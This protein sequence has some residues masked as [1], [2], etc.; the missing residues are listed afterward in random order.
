MAELLLSID[1]GNQ[2]ANPGV[3]MQQHDCS[4][5]KPRCT[6]EL[7]TSDYLADDLHCVI[8]AVGRDARKWLLR[9]LNTSMQQYRT[10]CPIGSW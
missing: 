2:F 8:G 6:G 9:P 10:S 4:I 1:A 3:D 7:L 5:T